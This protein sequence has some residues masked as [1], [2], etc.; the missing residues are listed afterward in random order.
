MVAD[1]NGPGRDDLDQI[2]FQV[3]PSS[4]K[5]CDSVLQTNKREKADM[6]FF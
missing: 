2:I 4:K 6:L 1:C 5:I 3:L